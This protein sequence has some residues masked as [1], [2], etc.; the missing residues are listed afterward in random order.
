LIRILKL[1]YALERL[2]EKEIAYSC[3]RQMNLK[4]VSLFLLFLFSIVI[5]FPGY[6][7]R[8][9]SD[10]KSQTLQVSDLTTDFPSL[11][12]VL[13]KC[14][15]KGI[16]MVEEER[17]AEE[18]TDNAPIVFDLPVNFACSNIETL[19]IHIGDYHE[20]ECELIFTGI[21]TPPDYFIS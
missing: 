12:I 10:A 2:E 20:P 21:Y 15:A 7:N 6:G 5:A 1:F 4:P 19:P 3:K 9:Q 18:D 16:N 8:I 13:K 14:L 11:I 17:N